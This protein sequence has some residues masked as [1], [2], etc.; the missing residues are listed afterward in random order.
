MYDVV[1]EVSS[2]TMQLFQV[3]NV[4]FEVANDGGCSH[5]RYLIITSAVSYHPNLFQPRGNT[6]FG[7]DGRSAETLATCVHALS[8]KITSS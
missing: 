6:A 5:A 2:L 7:H 8:L 3:D 4:R 1:L